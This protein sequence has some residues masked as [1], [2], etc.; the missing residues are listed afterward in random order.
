MSKGKKLIT[1]ACVFVSLSVL[2][3][4]S[5]SAKYITC[6]ETLIMDNDAP[7]GANYRNPTSSNGHWT[8]YP[9][10]CWGMNTVLSGSNH[11]N[12]KARRGM[13][14]EPNFGQGYMYG[15]TVYAWEWMGADNTSSGDYVELYVKINDSTFTAPV[16]KYF[17]HD[18]N[19]Y[20]EPKSFGTINQNSWPG[21]LSYLGYM[22][23]SNPS[24][25]PYIIADGT[26]KRNNG[27]YMG[28]DE[29][30]YIHT[31]TKYVSTK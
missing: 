20:V 23:L 4:Y 11:F 9:K 3:T 12:Q 5:Y 14:S 10:K 17:H 25:G 24:Y 1:G 6:T 15:G 18:G 22:I 19:S 26:H 7:A 27:H 8:Y 29:I 31:Y 13:C 2:S 21:S 30:K 16:V 28:A